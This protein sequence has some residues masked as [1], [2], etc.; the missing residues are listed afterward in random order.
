MSAALAS[1][2]TPAETLAEC[3]RSDLL[4]GLPRIEAV[5]A[6]GKAAPSGDKSAVLVAAHT[7]TDVDAQVRSAAVGALKN[8][9]PG[10]RVG[11]IRATASQLT[12]TD[13]RV[14]ESA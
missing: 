8:L 5:K 3:C 6:L 12:N 2:S 10:D 4:R 11:S 1:A 7:L 9:A 14:R 13:F